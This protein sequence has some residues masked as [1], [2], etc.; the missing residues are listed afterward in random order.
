M[1]LILYKKQKTEKMENKILLTD[2]N[3]EAKEGQLLLSAIALISNQFKFSFFNDGVKSDFTEQY[4]LENI[5]QTRKFL[6]D[7][8]DGKSFLYNAV[9][10]SKRF[11]TM[12]TECISGTKKCFDKCQLCA[13][14]LFSL[15]NN[16][17]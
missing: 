3:L 5:E 7:G 11:H 12:P 10:A 13:P 8:G 6:V 16:H 4:I 2:L 14:R 15:A 17:Y 9:E 1:V